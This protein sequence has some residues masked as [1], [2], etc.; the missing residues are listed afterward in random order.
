MII[1][2]PSG[3]TATTSHTDREAAIAGPG[4]G[5]D[6]S[7]NPEYKPL[8]NAF[9]EHHDVAATSEAIQ[10]MLAGGTPNWVKWPHE[11]KAYA[12]ECFAAE[13]ENSDRMAAQYKW[14]DQ[15]MLTNEAARKVNPVSTIEFIKKL[16]TNGIKCTVMDNGL[17]GTLGLWCVPPN[18]TDKLRYVC[19][20]QVPA[21][22]E[23]SILRLD[24][25]GIP[26]G[27][28]FRGWRT[29]AV[30]LVE[31]EII[32]EQ[33]CHQIF[34]VP[35]PN[36]ISARYFRSLWEKRNGRR[37]EDEDERGLSD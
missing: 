29:V 9:N 15:E 33:Q 14:N 21:M 32:T 16:K 35:S 24:D 23:W 18:R 8:E 2:L 3:S 12:K 31:K 19:F 20:I 34:G 30:Q 26:S 6:W 7:I 1:I 27:E 37:Y 22:Y 13:K 17:K 4:A 36:T 5:A 11:Y 28:K 10:Q 25:H